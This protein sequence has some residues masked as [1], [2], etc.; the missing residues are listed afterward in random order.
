MP[1]RNTEQLENALKQAVDL[2]KF[3]DDNEEN[4]QE[5]T[6]AEYLKHLLAKKNLTM[7]QVIRD[8]QLGTY[9]YQ[10]FYGNKKTSREYVLSLAFAMRLSPRETDYL[11]YYAGHKKLYPRS[12]WDSVIFFALTNHKNLL[13]TNEMLAE[14]KLSPLLGRLID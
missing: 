7:T 4:F 12:K 11:L 2:K 10:I 14:F 3:L 13:E 9:A 8:S 6:L 5:F 1:A